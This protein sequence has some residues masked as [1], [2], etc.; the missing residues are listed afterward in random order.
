MTYMCG[1]SGLTLQLIAEGLI[2]P[3]CRKWELILEAGKVARA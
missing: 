2:P 1:P 3:R